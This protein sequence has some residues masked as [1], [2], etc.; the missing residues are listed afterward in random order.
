M[1]SEQFRCCLNVSKDMTHTVY[2]LFERVQRHDT[3]SLDVNSM[4][5]ILRL[6]DSYSGKVVTFQESLFA[7]PGCYWQLPVAARRRRRDVF[8][9]LRLQANKDS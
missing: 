1:L 5:V 2:M 6:C 8:E 4:N 3:H 7:S 9:S